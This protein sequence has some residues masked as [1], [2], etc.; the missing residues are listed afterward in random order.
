MKKKIPDF[1]LTDNNL[2]V[3]NKVKYLGDFIT[4]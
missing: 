1:I 2:E 4:E 3:A